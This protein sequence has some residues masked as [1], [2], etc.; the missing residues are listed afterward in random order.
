M[1]IRPVIRIS[2]RRARHLKLG[3]RALDGVLI[4]GPDLNFL[5]LLAERDPTVSLEC[6]GALIYE[7]QVQ[8][9]LQRALY[10]P[11]RQLWYVPAS[12]TGPLHPPSL[13]AS[14]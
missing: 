13:A 14:I 5:R 2:C 8:A 3:A 4:T 11:D 6:D 9:L 12:D 1:A 7:A 10:L